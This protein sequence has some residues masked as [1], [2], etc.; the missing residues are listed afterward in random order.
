MEGRKKLREKPTKLN[1]SKNGEKVMK[2]R[3]LILITAL[4]T[5][6]KANAQNRDFLEAIAEKTGTLLGTTSRAMTRRSLKGT[7][8]DLE[9]NK[10]L[11][12]K[13]PLRDCWKE[14]QVIDEKVI[15]CMQEDD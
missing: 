9:K 15:E 14:K 2:K 5:A 7:A 10:P 11:E 6:D 1:R 4:L 12:L 13:K 8:L 3:A